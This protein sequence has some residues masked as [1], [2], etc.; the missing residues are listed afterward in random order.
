MSLY[1]KLVEPEYPGF[2]LPA[3]IVYDDEGAPTDSHYV[4]HVRVRDTVTV[5]QTQVLEV[6]GKRGGAV[7]ETE[8][9]IFLKFY[10]ITIFTLK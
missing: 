7:R 5:L 3:V 2:D 10:W 4:L 9:L 8:R 1:L 6:G